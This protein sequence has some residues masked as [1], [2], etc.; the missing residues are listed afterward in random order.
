[1]ASVI[2]AARSASHTTLG[3]GARLRAPGGGP[4]G[5]SLKLFGILQTLG[6]KMVLKCYQYYD[7]NVT[8][9]KMK[10]GRPTGSADVGP[11]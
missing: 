2:M 7:I 8:L 5:F 9:C 6:E 1:M 3:P 10:I 11:T 4:G